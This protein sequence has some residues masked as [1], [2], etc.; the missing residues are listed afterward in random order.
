VFEVEFFAGS[1]EE[2]VILGQ[3]PR[4]TAFDIMHPELIEQAGDSELVA[5]RE[6]YPLLL[7]AIP[8]SGVVDLQ[9]F[10]LFRS[11]SRLLRWL[12]MKKPSA[13]TKG[14]AHAGVR[15]APTR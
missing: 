5:N 6:R 1:C 13:E 2:F 10:H 12:T 8:Q 7:R 4:P 15:R 3:G 14:R 11:S 9:R